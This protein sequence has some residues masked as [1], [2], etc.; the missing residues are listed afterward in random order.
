MNKSYKV[1]YNRA[2]GRFVAV[3]ETSR[4]FSDRSRSFKAISQSALMMAVSTAL[5][6]LSAS[7]GAATYQGKVDPVTGQVK[8]VMGS[9]TIVID[10]IGLASAASTVSGMPG[11]KSYGASSADLGASSIAFGAG[12]SATGDYAVAYGNQATAGGNHS[13]AIG[14]QA[15]TMHY[16]AKLDATIRSD[17]ANAIGYKAS[18]SNYANA[19]GWQA[20]ASEFSNAIGFFANTVDNNSN[21]IGWKASAAYGASALGY[22]AGASGQDSI[23]IGSYANSR[24]TYSLAIGPKALSMSKNSSALGYF[25]TATAE[26]SLALGYK[27]VADENDTVSVGRAQGTVL[28]GDEGAEIKRRIVHVADGLHGT[29]AAT[30]A[31]TSTLQLSEGESNLKLQKSTNNNDSTRYTLSVEA[32]NA[33]TADA[34]GLA[35][36]RA[37]YDE[38]RPIA[39]TG[40]TFNVISNQATAENLKALDRAVGNLDHLTP[41]GSTVIRNLAK[42]AVKVVPGTNTTV[43]TGIEGDATTYAVNVDAAG[44]IT[45]E[46]N[47]IVTGATVKAYLDNLDFVSSGALSDFA[48]IDASNV[49]DR[50]ADWAAAIGK[51]EIVSGNSLLLT[52]DKV[53]DEVHLD[54]A[55]TYKYVSAKNTTA[56]NIW[57]LD[58]A[59]KALEGRIDQAGTGTAEDLDRIENK[60]D[61][62]Q[63]TADKAHQSH[64]TVVSSDGTL[65]VT[66]TTNAN[67]QTEYDVTISETA[68]FTVRQTVWKSESGE[69]STANGS[70]FFSG[71]KSAAE[72]NAYVSNGVVSAGKDAQT[73][74]VLDGNT[75]KAS[76]GQ[77]VTI[78]GGTGRISGVAAGEISE[79]STDAVNGS[80]LY[81]VQ[82]G[83]AQNTEGLEN[84]GR[85]VNKVD[86]KIDRTGALAA[87]LA[88]LHPQDYDENHPVS[89]AVG[90]GHYKGKQALAAGMFV[91][92]VEN[93]MVSLGASGSADDY[94]LNFGASFR[95]GGASLQRSP[96]QMA[97]RL[98]DQEVTIRDL[99]AQNQAQKTRLESQD[100]KFESQAAQIESQQSE[101]KAQK[102]QLESQ[103]SEIAKLKALV[104]EIQA[105][106]AK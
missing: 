94:M 66:G 103:S 55:N 77:T 98:S 88:A 102:A 37:V 47:R 106:L 73:R 4:A 19:I 6:A 43:D 78:D 40:E 16:N 58:R 54:A 95:F 8:I 25:A 76:F 50:A 82:Q 81:V 68:D 28:E 60:A 65:K 53:Y 105:K 10:G 99:S 14:D 49:A 45:D 3:S 5:F 48:K 75:G 18:A 46:D 83:L 84:L 92:P 42:G 22:N 62:A 104:A 80:Q 64:T 56:D 17:Y 36:A 2:R 87:A 32:S 44:T 96:T 97:A 89:G 71:G 29:E 59:L 7:V 72:A 31:Q 85:A 38:V 30:V 1:V 100:A 11:L 21:A 34:A 63:A 33:I 23:A 12:A 24:G 15:Q 13:V 69:V 20:T 79:S 61:S 74:I 26:Q 70:G 93:F 101:L 90:I 27:S 86:R 39:G 35:T 9:D 91:R 67:G 41:A 57:A 52:A 51:G